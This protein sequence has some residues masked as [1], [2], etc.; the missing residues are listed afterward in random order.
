M[1]FEHP[2]ALALLLPAALAVWFNRRTAPAPR[3]EVAYGWLWAEVLAEDGLRR[4]WLRWREPVS[5]AVAMMTFGFLIVVLAGPLVPPPREAVLVLDVSASMSATDT[6]PSR[7]DAAKR[8]AGEW[9]DAIDV[10]DRLA[11][12]TAGR[13]AMVVEP[14]GSDRRRLA[15]ALRAIEPEEGPARLADAL[16]LACGMLA[17]R[18]NGR[19]VVL[20]DQPGE[21]I[22]AGVAAVAGQGADPTVEDGGAAAQADGGPGAHS[23][24]PAVPEVSSS[25]SV[26]EWIRLGRAQGNVAITRAAARQ[27][28]DRPNRHLVL[29]EVTNYANEPARRRLSF[30]T[31]SAAGAD[32]LPRDED[33]DLAPDGRWHRVVAIGSELG[34][35]EARL[36]PGDVLPGDDRAIVALGDGDSPEAAPSVGDVAT[37]AAPVDSPAAVTGA[38]DTSHVSRSGE[39][40]PVDRLGPFEAR[41]IFTALERAAESDLRIAPADEVPTPGAP[42][43]RWPIRAAL[44]LAAAVLAVV[45]WALYQRRWLS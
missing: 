35:I 10:P 22:V 40:R 19:I 9:I 2:W 42:K 41:A 1:A 17:G 6:Q 39:G 45:E 13:A 26:V 20:T 11:I 7:L 30:A 18:P 21:A 27:D 8:L 33:I 23:A 28:P 14:L 16:E 12:V 15:E 44:V 43:R 34:A 31:R 37:K 25:P 36:S 4:R 32:C 29:L 3:A 38:A 24:T 5:L